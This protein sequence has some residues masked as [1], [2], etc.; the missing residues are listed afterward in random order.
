MKIVALRQLVSRG[1]QG[2]VMELVGDGNNDMFKVGDVVFDH[3]VFAFTSI[4][5]QVTWLEKI[6]LDLL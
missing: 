6:C 3:I 5:F 4:N 1:I 2:L